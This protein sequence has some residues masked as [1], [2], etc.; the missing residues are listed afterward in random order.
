M[1]ETLK[2][3]KIVVALAATSLIA[4]MSL[5]NA[6]FYSDPGSAVTL[7]ILHNNDGESALLPDRSF[8]TA[9]GT[10]IFGSAAAFSSVM[11]R[12][13]KAAKSARNALL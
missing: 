13:V 12:E 11:K 1:E 5:A 2:L 6:S 7:T 9:Q 3:K 4:Q 8:K 10:L